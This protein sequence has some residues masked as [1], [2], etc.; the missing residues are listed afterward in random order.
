MEGAGWR[1]G[2]RG[3]VGGECRRRGESFP[4]PIFVLEDGFTD[5]NSSLK[6]ASNKMLAGHSQPNDDNG[7]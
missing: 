5:G 2:G 7:S 6:K 1:W 4:S 3:D